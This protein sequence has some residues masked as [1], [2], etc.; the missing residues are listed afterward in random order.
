LMCMATCLGCKPAPELDVTI[1]PPKV[2]IP[3]NSKRGTRLA[4]ILVQWSHYGTEA[5]CIE[6]YRAHRGLAQEPIT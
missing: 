3:D 5:A 1:N 2:T 6:D 4:T